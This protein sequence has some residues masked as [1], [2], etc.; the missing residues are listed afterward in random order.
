MFADGDNSKESESNHMVSLLAFGK[1]MYFFNLTFSILT[2][3][4]VLPSP[5]VTFASPPSTKE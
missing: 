5:R 3:S 4:M 1:D 2:F